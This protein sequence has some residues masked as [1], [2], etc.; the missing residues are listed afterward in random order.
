MDVWRI[1]IFLIWIDDDNVLW[2]MWLVWLMI[3]VIVNNLIL[4]VNFIEGG[5]VVFMVFVFW[6]MFKEWKCRFY[7]SGDIL[8]IYIEFMVI[9][10]IFTAW[11][12]VDYFVYLYVWSF[13]DVYLVKYYG[14]LCLVY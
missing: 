3:S 2:L 10:Y 8:F 4:K 9:I 7:N 14:L 6:R 1:K 11:I 5:K 12:F 13:Y